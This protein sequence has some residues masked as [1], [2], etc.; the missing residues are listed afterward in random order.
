MASKNV[1]FLLI[2]SAVPFV[3]LTESQFIQEA[4][5]PTHPYWTV[6]LQNFFPE[7]VHNIKVTGA[8]PEIVAR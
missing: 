3:S 7:I 2:Q 6:L 5:P 8:T 4:F 1:L